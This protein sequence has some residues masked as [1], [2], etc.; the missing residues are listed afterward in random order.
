MLW[1]DESKKKNH[2]TFTEIRLW[3]GS[4]RWTLRMS[5]KF[6]LT[7]WIFYV[8]CD[9]LSSWCLFFFNTQGFN[10]ILTHCV[11]QKR[12]LYYPTLTDH[13]DKKWLGIFGES[14]TDVLGTNFKNGG[15]YQTSGVSCR[16]S[17][18]MS[19]GRAEPNAVWCVMSPVIK[20]Q[21][22]TVG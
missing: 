17:V 22:V 13:I 15:G 12:D 7:G 10:K 2:R 11:T 21:A 16:M 4:S 18:L 5:W 20:W 14:F 3:C 8:S 1:L 9:N 6:K 19:A